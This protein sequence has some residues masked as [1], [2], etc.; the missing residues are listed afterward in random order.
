MWLAKLKIA[1]IQKDA[2]ALQ[3]LLRDV[4]QFQEQRE[5]EEALYLLKE[6]TLQMEKLKEETA[7]SM[8]T[9]RKNLEFLRAT[10]GRTSENLD[11]R[12]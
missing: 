11:I 12:L 10:D 6:A 3:K 1:V 5:R 4:P 8:R 9:I 7:A 2:A